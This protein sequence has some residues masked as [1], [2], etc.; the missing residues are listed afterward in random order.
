[1]ATQIY[2]LEKNVELVNCFLIIKLKKGK[3]VR[4]HNP[5]VG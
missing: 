1:M 5:Y 3:S 2:K 4:G